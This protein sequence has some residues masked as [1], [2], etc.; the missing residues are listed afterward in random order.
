MRYYVTGYYTNNATLDGKYRCIKIALASGLS[1]SLDYREGYFAGKQFG[2]S[3]TAEKERQLE[4]ALLLGDPIT[5]LTIAMEIDYFELNRTEYFTPVVV[6]IPGSELALAK[7]GG[8]EHTLPDFIG[9]IKDDFG[10]TVSNVSDKVDI[11]LSDA[12]AAELA[13]RPIQYD[14]GFTLLPG[15]YKIKFPAGDAETGGIGT[16]ETR[17]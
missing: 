4:D 1:A 16:Y 3:T 15:K 5:E 14:T 6:K 12:T 7:R 17:L 2:K 11:K 10:T 8:A 9:A 13:K